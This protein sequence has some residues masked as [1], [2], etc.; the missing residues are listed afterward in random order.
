M[1]LSLSLPTEPLNACIAVIMAPKKSLL[2]LIMLGLLR[3]QKTRLLMI[4]KGLAQLK[5]QQL[6]LL[7]NGIPVKKFISVFSKEQSPLIQEMQ[8]IWQLTNSLSEKDI[9]TP[10]QLLIQIQ[11]GLYGLEKVK[12][13][14]RLIV[15]SN[16]V[17]QKDVSK[18]KQQPW[19]KM[20]VLLLVLI[21]IALM[22]RLFM[23]CSIW[24]ITTQDLL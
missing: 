23:T 8:P 24:F 14:V 6:K 11:G 16:S 15:S 9:N 4:Q 1:R 10:Q 5:I 13:L 20:L 7:L 2:F 12:K 22:L 17:V 3:D 21:S 18:L 19:T